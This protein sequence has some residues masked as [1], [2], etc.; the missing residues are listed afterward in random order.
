M[1]TEPRTYVRLVVFDSDGNPI[2]GVAIGDI[3]AACEIGRIVLEH[4]ALVDSVPEADEP[5]VTIVREATQES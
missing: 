5:F 4:Y 1:T 3:N 2:D